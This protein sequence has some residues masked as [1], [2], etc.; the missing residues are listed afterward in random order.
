MSEGELGTGL[1]MSRLKS[2]HRLC[3][4]WAVKNCAIIWVMKKI[5]TSYSISHLNLY[6]ENHKEYALVF[7]KNTQKCKK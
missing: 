1:S 7:N 2:L 6:T 4:N 3:M 5:G